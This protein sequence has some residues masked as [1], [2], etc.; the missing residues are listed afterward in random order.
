[1]PKLEL[2]AAKATP[3]AGAF[4]DWKATAFADDQSPKDNGLAKPKTISAKAG[5]ENCV[6]HVGD[7]TK[8]KVN[9]YVTKDKAPDVFLAPKWAVDRILVKPDDLKKAGGPRRPQPSR[10][11]RSP[12]SR[13]RSS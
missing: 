13:R 4:K 1:K 9:Y 12:S 11:S 6:V 10:A 2:D 8:D 5:K 7:E 3:I